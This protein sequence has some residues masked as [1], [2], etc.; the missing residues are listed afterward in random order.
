MLKK[1][2]SDVEEGYS[3]ARDAIKKGIGKKA[4]KKISGGVER[5]D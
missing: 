4:F 5:I 2:A 3:I 1:D